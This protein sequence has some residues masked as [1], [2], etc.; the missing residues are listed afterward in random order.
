MLPAKR[1]PRI[2]LVLLLPAC[3]FS[4]TAKEKVEA[5]HRT[6]NTVTYPGGDFGSISDNAITL[7]LNQQLLWG[8]A[9]QQCDQKPVAY[10]TNDPQKLRE[11]KSKQH[12][13][14]KKCGRSGDVISCA[15]SKALTK[16]AADDLSDV[17]YEQDCYMAAPPAELAGKLQLRVV[18]G[19][20]SPTSYSAAPILATASLTQEAKPESFNLQGNITD[21]QCLVLTDIQGTPV[22][23]RN[24]DGDNYTFATQGMRS[25][26]DRL[27]L[28]QR[29]K[30][31]QDSIQ[32]QRGLIRSLA[33]QLADDPAVRRSASRDSYQCARPAMRPLPPEPKSGLSWDGAAEQAQGYC[34]DKLANNFDQ[35]LIWQYIK[36]MEEDQYISSYDAFSRKKNSCTRKAYEYDPGTI[37]TMRLFSFLNPRENEKRQVITL[38]NQCASS[39]ARRCASHLIAWRDEVDR[40]KSEPEQIY[41]ACSGKASDLEAATRKLQ[42]MERD[43]ASMSR[44]LAAYQ[45]PLADSASIPL[46]MAVCDAHR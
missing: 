37:Q 26:K 12:D 35:G 5:Y 3:S 44:E 25:S 42:G 1:L 6:Q 45:Q 40:I 10:Q 31:T 33:S 34:L 8:Q 27:A 23:V 14:Q 11:M 36:A 19:N 39:V 20:T 4:P 15:V 28:Q 32:K 29:L 9:R 46:S 38:L 41:A 43:V 13:T 24:S 16:N 2:F 17:R 7:T 30:S 21:S 22:R 18:N